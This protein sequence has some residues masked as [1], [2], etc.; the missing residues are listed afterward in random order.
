MFLQVRERLHHGPDL[1][2]PD[3]HGRRRLADQGKVWLLRHPHHRSVFSPALLAPKRGTQRERRRDK[4]LGVMNNL[5]F[6]RSTEIEFDH[7]FQAVWI[8]DISAPLVG[9]LILYAFCRTSLSRTRSF[10]RNQHSGGARM[11]LLTEND[12]TQQNLASW[13]ASCSVSSLAATSSSDRTR[14]RSTRS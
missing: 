8:P 10:W 2:R 6:L 14:R 9:R 5:S 7:S 13:A 12:V 11:T 1:P 4:G 3:Q